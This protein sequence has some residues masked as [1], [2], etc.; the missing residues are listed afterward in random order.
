MS[1]IADS[2]TDRLRETFLPVFDPA[3]DLED[4]RSLFYFRKI[5]DQCLSQRT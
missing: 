3:P 4:P 2:D 1:R 5:G